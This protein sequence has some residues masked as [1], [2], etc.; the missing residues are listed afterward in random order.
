MTE[1][2]S[3]LRATAEYV[4]HTVGGILGIIIGVILALIGL[5]MGVTMVMLPLG[6]VIGL[7][8]MLLIVASASFRSGG[9][10]S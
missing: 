7:A 5:A 3:M 2:K 9:E 8:G 10:E 1:K 6:I 4:E